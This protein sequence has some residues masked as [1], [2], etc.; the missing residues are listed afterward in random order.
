VT[1][2]LGLH[3]RTGA[4]LSTVVGRAE[5]AGARSLQVFTQSPRSWGRAP[6]SPERLFELRAQIDASPTVSVLLCHATYLINLAA[7]DDAVRSNSRRCLAANLAGATAVG[8]AGLVL[9]PGSHRGAGWERGARRIVD[10]LRWSLDATPDPCKILLENT[11]GSGDTMGRSFAELGRLVELAGFDERLGVCLDSQ[12][13]FAG[14]F[15]FAS[16]A[17]MD[18]VVADLD[19]S[20]GLG[21][22]RAIHFNDSQVPFA[23]QRDR[24]ASLG[25]GM[26]G[27]AALR[28][29][30]GHP[31]LQGLPVVIETPGREGGDPGRADVDYARALRQAGRRRYA[32]VPSARRPH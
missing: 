9:H 32:A 28:C 2:L 29:F 17:A 14:G 4:G 10:G 1:A 12:H 16:P 5:A 15:D 18:A 6:Q 26:I 27:P 19:R 24:H 31:R 7:P 20:V 25:M 3:L 23:S 30:L 11:A 22:L 13:L 21:R 8:A